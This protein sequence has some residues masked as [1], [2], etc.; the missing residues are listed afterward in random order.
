VYLANL[1]IDPQIKQ[2]MKLD[3][4]W[5]QLN[6]FDVL[7]IR[8]RIWI[9]GKGNSEVARP[10]LEISELIVQIREKYIRLL[11]LSHQDRK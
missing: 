9:N 3:S 7:Q 5:A 1:L 6:F 4:L 10:H 11:D 8:H 2:E